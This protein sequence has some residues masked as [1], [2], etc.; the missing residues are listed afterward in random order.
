MTILPSDVRISGS[1][2]FGEV[3]AGELAEQDIDICNVG[4]SDLLVSSV[5]FDPACDDFTLI[6]NPFPANVSHDFCL[7]VTIRCT[8][9]AAG[10]HTCNLEILTN[11]PDSPEV[12]LS[13]TG[14]TPLASIGVPPD[15]GFLPEV[16]QSVGVCE[17]PASF[18]ISNTGTCPLTITDVSL[19]GTSPGDYGL[20][21]LPS[22]PIL[23]DSGHIAGDGDLEVVF[24]PTVLDRAREADLMVTYESD[25]VTGTTTTETRSLCGEGVYTGARVLVTENGVPMATVKRIQIQRINANRNRDRLDTVD[26]SND[27]T[28]ESVA[29]GAPC[30][31]FQYHKEYGTVANPIQLLPGSYNVNVSARING[32]TKK[33]SVGFDV[34]TC[35][36][37]PTVVVDF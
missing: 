1:S 34:T 26:T 3:C 37:N 20:S 30:P 7:P 8:P 22:F 18:P 31:S 23:L 17:T 16:L 33:K 14:N 29:P 25:P 5:S 32:K 11:D 10:V 24:A 9:T 35:D 13:V 27:L 19:G 6:N 28:L 4:L 15:L 2:D 12:N 21:G 36:F